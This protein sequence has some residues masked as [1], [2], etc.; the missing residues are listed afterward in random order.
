MLGDILQNS[1]CGNNAA[2]EIKQIREELMEYF[3][4]KGAIS[5]QRK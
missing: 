4:N 5:W 1:K 3:T 2:I